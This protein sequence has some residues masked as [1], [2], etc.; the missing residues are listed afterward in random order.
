MSIQIHNMLGWLLG[1]SLLLHPW[2]W[3]ALLQPWGGK[4]SAGHANGREEWTKVLLVSKKALM[5]WTCKR[6]FKRMWSS[7]LDVGSC[8][9]LSP[10]PPELLQLA[11]LDELLHL[12]L[13][14]SLV[15]I[16]IRRSGTKRSTGRKESAAA[17]ATVLGSEA[18]L[19]WACAEV[20][21]AGERY[22]ARN[23]ASN[24]AQPS[25]RDPSGLGRRLWRSHE[26]AYL[27][28]AWWMLRGAGD[29]SAATAAPARR[30]RGWRPEIWAL[31]Q[32][33]RDARFLKCR[34]TLEGEN[35]AG[36]AVH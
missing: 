5:T 28:A 22:G 10:P 1:W 33:G 18:E 29:S 8:C 14:L 7:R 2:C 9:L 6:S 35:I 15:H 36:F 16:K 20:G 26:V 17:G 32:P 25:R 3:Y 24:G 31:W 12:Q 11:K 19:Q 13:V 23:W 30:R 27:R 4:E 21:G 34:C